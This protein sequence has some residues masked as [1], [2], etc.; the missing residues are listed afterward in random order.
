MVETQKPQGRRSRSRP[1]NDV[2]D[3]RGQQDQQ[4]DRDRDRRDLRSRI[5]ASKSGN[6]KHQ[7]QRG[8]N[9]RHHNE[10]RDYNNRRKGGDSKQ[11]DLRNK[12]GNTSNRPPRRKLSIDSNASTK[13]TDRYWKFKS[14]PYKNVGWFGFLC[15]YIAL[16]PYMV[17]SIV[18]NYIT[19]IIIWGT[20]LIDIEQVG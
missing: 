19:R 10:N 4:R 5:E 1:D 11:G 14:L 16:R 17:Q 12:I 8:P 15:P 13:T 6:T 7:H 9:P 3:R 20:R 2:E 18:L